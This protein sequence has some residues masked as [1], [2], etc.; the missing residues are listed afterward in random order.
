[1]LN[2]AQKIERADS[3]SGVGN[4]LLAPPMSALHTLS[5][6]K[7]V[8][9]GKGLS[10]LG[11]QV[12][13]VP[14]VLPGESVLA[15]IGHKRH[16]VHQADVVNITHPSSERRVPPCQIFG[17]CGGCQFQHQTY[18]SQ[19]A[20]K[21]VMLREA[22]L[23][24]GKLP[25]DSIPEV[26]PSPHP[27]GYRTVVRL[28]VF[29]N[30][31]RFQLGFFREGTRAYIHAADCLLV[32]D[33]VRGMMSAVSERLAAQRRLPLFLHSIEIRWSECSKNALLVFRGSHDGLS[34]VH[35]FLALFDDL[36]HMSGWIFESTKSD[37]SKAPKPP[38]VQ[39][40]DYLI[41]RFESLTLRIGY[42]AFMQANWAIYEAIGRTLTEW[43]GDIKGQRILELF[44]GVGALGLSLAR[45]GALVTLVEA[46][47]FALSDARQS[48]N[49]SHVGRC[50]FRKGAVESFFSST[51]ADPYE[52]VLVDPPR[53]GLSE[54]ATKEIG[55]IRPPR[56]FYVSCDPATLARDLSRLSVYGY[57]I[58]RVQPFDMFPQTAHIETLVEL[59][60]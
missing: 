42:R 5:I 40:Q 24:I 50:R 46:N 35:S 33:A 16:G 22:L 27:F 57:H 41:Q 2:S 54:L 38:V 18:E 49:L 11:T 12:V 34:H 21:R 44:A 39:G 17:Q 59:T 56:L 32:P 4:T 58:T 52:V 23:R 53:T 30:K 14:G 3:P 29:Q 43:I 9:G 26:I 51:K 55:T 15:R 10:R 31:G 20:Q 7:V 45:K 19:L 25:I 36:P 48:A 13:L 8:A 28:A 6:E 1:M 37:G 47:S 60:V